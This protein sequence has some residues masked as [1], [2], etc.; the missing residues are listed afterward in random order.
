[1]EDS[2]KPITRE[3]IEAE[4]QEAEKEVALIQFQLDEV[5]NEGAQGI[6]DKL[7]NIYSELEGDLP[8]Q[9]KQKLRE[10]REILYRD[11]L[12]TKCS[13]TSMRLWRAKGRRDFSLKIM[14]R[15]DA[16]PVTPLPETSVLETA[17][18]LV[19]DKS[20]ESKSFSSS[21]LLSL[22]LLATVTINAHSK[23]K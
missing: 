1:M 7:N 13:A 23:Q 10:K 19:G 3:Q 15:R 9:E 4:I 11:P 8:P 14:K 2:R 6:L 5:L 21:S 16:L 17:A 22:H 20:A 18:L 12:W